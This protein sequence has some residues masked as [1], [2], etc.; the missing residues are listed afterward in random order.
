MGQNLSLRSVLFY[1]LKTG[2]VFAVYFLAARFGLGISPV[3]GFATLVWPPTGIALVALFIWGWRLWPGIFL[4][5]FLVNLLTGAPILGAL[6]IALGNTLEAVVGSLLLKKFEFKS[7]LERLSDVLKLIGIAAVLSTAISATVGVTSLFLVGIVSV[8]SYLSTWTAWW[9]GDALGDLVVAPFLFIW[10]R[11]FRLA[12]KIGKAFEH[13]IATAVLL[14]TCFFVF[15]DVG[16][17]H[18]PSHI[19]LIFPPLIWFA[20]RFGQRSVV[21]VNMIVSAIAIWGTVHGVGHFLSMEISDSLLQLQLFMGVFSVTIMVL[22]AVVAERKK[23]EQDLKVSKSFIEQ[24]QVKDEA[25]LSS[26]GDGVIATNQSGEVIFMNKASERM[27][28]FSAKDFQGKRVVDVL[29]IKDIK[30]NALPTE[31]RPF[32]RAQT[33]KT[34]I[35]DPINYLYIKKDGGGLPVKITASPII[36]NG[37]IIGTMVVFRDI[38]DELR[39]DK[40]KS[41]FISVASHQLRTPVKTLKSLTKLLR[42]DFEKMDTKSKSHFKKLSSSVDWLSKLA[43]NLLN[44]SR[45]EAGVVKAE[46]VNINLIE[47]T[48][49]FIKDINTYASIQKHKLVFEDKLKESKSIK[50]DPKLLYNTLQNFTANAIEY[51]PVGTPVVI[52]LEDVGADIKISVSHGGPSISKEEQEKLFQKFYRG[53]TGKSLRPEGAGLGLYIVKSSAE[54]MGGKVGFESEKGKDTVFWFTLP[55]TD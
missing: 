14:I 34:T 47:F 30:G 49:S 3:S 32:F 16:P 12:V 38:T 17:I 7:S 36:L 19:Y 13:L 9:V 37:K 18:S 53:N 35:S 8:S 11:G 54:I 15:V 33:S 23:A 40:A 50:T 4:A 2:L 55:K 46:K 28:G 1:L 52:T 29:T 25:L 48:E 20:I 43:E 42:S 41:E 31:K 39:L 24:E 21:L 5:A 6:G 27:L 26:V 44:I 45:L 10:L 51:S 22:A